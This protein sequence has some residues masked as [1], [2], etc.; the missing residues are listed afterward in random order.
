VIISDKVG[1]QEII[2]EGE[3]LVFTDISPEGIL[4]AI[5]TAMRSDFTVA[6]DFIQRKQLMI[7]DH[8]RALKSFA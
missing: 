8:V 6:P 5:Q 2:S 7:D 3:G 4:T 1:A